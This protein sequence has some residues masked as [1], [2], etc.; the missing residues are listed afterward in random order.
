MDSNGYNESIMDTDP[1]HDFITKNEVLETVRHEVYFGPLRPVS[2]RL[3]FW[4]YLSPKSHRMVHSGARVDGRSLDLLLKMQCQRVYERT[5]SR[6]EFMKI[7]G[8]NYL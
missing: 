6:D 4:V 2:K 3:G 8:R 1:G 5:H 7:T